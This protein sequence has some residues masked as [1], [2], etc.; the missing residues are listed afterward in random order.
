MNSS[1]PFG[2]TAISV[3]IA[4]SSRMQAQ[5]L[6][7]ALRRRSEFH[8]FTCSVDVSAILHTLSSTPAKVLLFSLSHSASIPSQMAVLR[9]V[10]QFYPAVEKVLLVE[11]ADRELIVSAFRSGIRGIFSISDAQFRLL[12]RCIQR[13][14]AGQVWMNSE[15]MRFLLE[16]V[17]EV[18]S[19]RVINSRGRELLT[20]REAQ[21]V[22]IVAEGFSNR[23]IARELILSE[24]T[25]KK[26]LFR[27][28]DKLGISSRVELVRYAVSHIDPLPGEWLPAA[29]STA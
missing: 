13:V 9:Q 5:L 6:T 16:L 1:Q 25:V 23:E 27:I 21:V 11:S 26:H 24:H 19:L 20:P 3:L 14:A 28:F 2:P 18:P 7:S 17:A 15:Q 22:A 29:K 12:C 4:D 10:H 8:I